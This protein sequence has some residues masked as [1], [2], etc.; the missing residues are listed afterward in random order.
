MAVVSAKRS[1]TTALVR[2]YV[3]DLT[4][5][6]STRASAISKRAKEIA[7]DRH[8][9]VMAAGATG[10]AAT[11]GAV[12]GATGAVGGGVVGAAVGVPA[13]LFTLGLSIPVCAAVGAAIG[14]GTG[15]TVGGTTGFVGGGAVGHYGYKHR[16]GIKGATS[17][18]V[19]KVGECKTYAKTKVSNSADYMSP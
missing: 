5:R 19:N 8:V 14:G 12:G 4:T 1:D 13:A 7:G 18:V 15:A 10:G 3:G 2:S 11:L 17:T 9:Q 6:A 16:E